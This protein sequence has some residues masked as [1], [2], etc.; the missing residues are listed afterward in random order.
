MTIYHIAI[1]S[2]FLFLALSSV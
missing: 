2:D 1:D